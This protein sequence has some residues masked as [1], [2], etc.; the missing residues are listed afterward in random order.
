MLAFNTDDNSTNNNNNNN[1]HVYSAF[2]DT[3]NALHCKGR[4]P[5]S[6]PVLGKV[7]FKRNTLQ[8]CVTP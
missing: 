8:Y 3:Q 6:Q 4:S 7:T 2:L 1:L 5:Q